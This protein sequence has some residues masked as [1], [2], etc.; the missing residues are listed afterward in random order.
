MGWCSGGI[1]LMFGVENW[2]ERQFSRELLID[3]VLGS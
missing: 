2:G 3:V 1:C